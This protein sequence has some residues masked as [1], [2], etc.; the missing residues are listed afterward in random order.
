MERPASMVILL[1]V[2]AVLS[3]VSAVTWLG[4]SGSWTDGD[5]WS[6]GAVP[7]EAATVVVNIS[8]NEIVYIPSNVTVASLTFFGGILEIAPTATLN[9]NTFEYQK[10]TI[11]GTDTD[12]NATST[13]ALLNLLG[14]STFSTSGRKRL[15]SVLVRQQV[16]TL[17]WDGGDLV[18]WNA[19]LHIDTNAT[20]SAS[21]SA[22]NQLTLVAADA[23]SKFDIY[24][25]SS[26]WRTLSCAALRASPGSPLPLGQIYLCFYCEGR[27][28]TL[29]CAAVGATARSSLY[30]GRND[31]Y[32]KS[33]EWTYG[34]RCCS[35]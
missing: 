35:S 9:I 5:M 2:L 1:L 28:Y 15:R 18:F 8:S 29:A 13:Q 16:D 10:G 20:L 21:G 26:P 3:R 23:K 34:G 12:Y 24:A 30:M 32:L 31:M 25:S 6:G 22:T 19:E 14:T 27:T 11:M 17:T 33:R 4:G 7:A